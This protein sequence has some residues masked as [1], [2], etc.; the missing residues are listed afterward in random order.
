MAEKL[1]NLIRERRNRSSTSSGDESSPLHETKRL[2]DLADTADENTNSDYEANYEN[3]IMEALSKIEHF[4]EQVNSIIA[5]LSKLDSI[6]SSVRNIETNLAYLKARTAKREE[7]EAPAKN[8]I[9]ELKKSCSF[10]GDKFKEHRD[11]DADGEA[12]KKIIFF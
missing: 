8:D 4:G 3:N 5:R 11:A 1:S 7:F 9:A 2:R 12:K 10:N 6:E